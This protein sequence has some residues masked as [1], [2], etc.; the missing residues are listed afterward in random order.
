MA[1]HV[2]TDGFVSIDGNDL[3]SSVQSVTLSEE[4]DAVDSTTFGE[5]QRSF[6]AGLSGAT[7]SVTFAQD[8]DAGAVY[9]LIEAMYQTTVP[10]IVRAFNAVVGANNPQW[11]F[12]ALV[13]QLTHIDATQGDLNTMDITWP[14]FD[15]VMTTA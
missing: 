9:Q 2:V 8:Y 4:T 12:N 10:C 6:V 13:N 5:T 7:F 1:K 3:S 14:A 11:A 15:I